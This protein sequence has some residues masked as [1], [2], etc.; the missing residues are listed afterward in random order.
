MQAKK[1]N[2]KSK[3]KLYRIKKSNAMVRFLFNVMKV[4]F[5]NNYKHKCR[6]LRLL[7]QCDNQLPGIV[8]H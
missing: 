6:N 5:I 3:Q 2:K 4:K 1:T 8:D 7:D